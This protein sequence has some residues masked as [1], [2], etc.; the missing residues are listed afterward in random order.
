VKPTK[1][2]TII[3]NLINKSIITLPV[4]TVMLDKGDSNGFCSFGIIDSARAGVDDGDI[5]YTPVDSSQGLWTV[6]STVASVNG[7]T[8]NRP[9][10]QAIIDSGTSICLVDTVTVKAIY[11][12]IPGSYFQS[13]N[14]G[15]VYPADAV[16]PTIQLA[17]GSTMFTINPADFGYGTAVSGS[18]L[19][20]GDT[21]GGV[22]DRGTSGTDVFG[23]IFLKVFTTSF[24]LCSLN[25]MKCR[26]SML[27]LIEERTA[28]GWRSE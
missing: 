12:A 13:A 4:F 10:N 11:S 1:Q 5:F 26:V 16:V 24:F 9:S 28:L 7:T 3:D 22:Q 23:D 27:S 25:L 6:S 8:I 15:W 14:N 17:I 20:P 21:F 18:I 19:G 2:K